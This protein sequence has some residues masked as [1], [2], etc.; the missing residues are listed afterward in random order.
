MAD[1]T[2]TLS[3]DDRAMILNLLRPDL[4]DEVSKFKHVSTA[5]IN[6]ETGGPYP[7]AAAAKALGIEPSVENRQNLI[8]AVR[9]QKKYPIPSPSE[10]TEH[11]QAKKGFQNDDN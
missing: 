9:V 10:I 5:L 8:N 11:F 2:I 4:Y 1:D 7:S 6:L 3:W